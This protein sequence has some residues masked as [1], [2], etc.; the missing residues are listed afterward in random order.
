MDRASFVPH[1]GRDDSLAAA[2]D[3]RKSGASPVEEMSE[4]IV[5]VHRSQFIAIVGNVLLAFAADSN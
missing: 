1:R 3:P 5:Q 4:L 2:L